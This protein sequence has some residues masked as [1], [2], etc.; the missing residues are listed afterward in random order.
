LG[1]AV[2]SSSLVI[3][4]FAVGSL[5][6]AVRAGSGFAPLE[7][8]GVAASGLALSAAAATLSPADGGMTVAAGGGITAGGLAGGAPIAGAVGVSSGLA[9][10]DLSAGRSQAAMP[11]VIAAAVNAAAHFRPSPFRAA[12]T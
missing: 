4:C 9:D 1:I 12:D 2:D 11:T 6:C 10:A 5:P 7:S 3:G 8:T